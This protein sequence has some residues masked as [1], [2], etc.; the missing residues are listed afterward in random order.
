MLSLFLL[1]LLLIFILAIPLIARYL[2][3]KI[4]DFEFYDK[5][6]KSFKG[7]I[8]CI[9]D[10]GIF[11]LLLGSVHILAE[12][13]PHLQLGLLLL[14][15]IGFIS[16]NMANFYGK[17]NVFQSKFMIW[18]TIWASLLRVNIIFTTFLFESEQEKLRNIIEDLQSIFIIL[19]L[20]LWVISLLYSLVHQV[21]E[22]CKIIFQRFFSAR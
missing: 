7:T 21:V 9:V 19:Y 11:N 17:N 12:K 13:T 20:F 22:T 15:Q 16:F 8:Y 3:K 1:F 4:R 6:K 5:C 18:I 10:F 14:I 2:Y